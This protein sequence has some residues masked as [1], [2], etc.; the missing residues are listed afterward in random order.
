MKGR[1][2]RLPLEEIEYLRGG[3]ND[4]QGRE[5]KNPDPTL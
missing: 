4:A 1:N 5:E 2:P 3:G